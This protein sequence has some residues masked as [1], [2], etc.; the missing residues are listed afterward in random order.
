MV[1]RQ[2]RSAVPPRAPTRPPVCHRWAPSGSDASALPRV[3]LVGKGVSFDTGGLDLKPANAMK[4]MKKDMGGAALVLG[5]AHAVMQVR[6]A[7][8]APLRAGPV[9]HADATAPRGRARAPAAALPPALQCR[10]PVSLRILVPAVEN[11]VSGNAFR[12]MDVLQTRAGITVENGNT[13]AEGRL[14]LVDALAEAD[15]EEPDLLLDAA[16]L[17]GAPLR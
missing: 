10:L 9:L 12:P 3:T 5:L 8:H 1:G 11:S 6:A 4:L 7:L 13:D 17:T 2:G 16:T 15:T 14:I